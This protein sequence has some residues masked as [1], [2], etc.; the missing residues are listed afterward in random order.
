MYHVYNLSHLH[1]RRKDEQGKAMMHILDLNLEGYLGPNSQR[2]RLAKVDQ[3]MEAA[4]RQL[5]CEQAAS[6][7]KESSLRESC[8]TTDLSRSQANT[9]L[10]LS[11]ER[12][13]LEEAAME[14]NKAK[15]KL[16][17]S[18]SKLNIDRKV[19]FNNSVMI[20][21]YILTPLYPK[22]F[23]A[24]KKIQSKKEENAKKAFEKAKEKNIKEDEKASSA[25]QK[26]AEA[27]LANTNKEIEKQVI[28][29][30]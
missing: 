13:E 26:A 1:I 24:D 21:C 29:C 30:Y 15:A 28:I 7:D 22:T 20:L 2:S 25:V 5:Q 27:K 10:R 9:I 18:K 12:A 4:D 3:A 17:L 19:N 11:T 23:E 6:S 16:E 14:V 8:K